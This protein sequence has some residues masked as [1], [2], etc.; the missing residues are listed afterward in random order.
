VR[1]AHS[2]FNVANSG[3]TPS[4]LARFGLAPRARKVR[5][6]SYC[7]LMIAISIGVEPSPAVGAL[8]SRA[9]V[10]QRFR[11]VLVAF[12]RRVVERGEAPLRADLLDVGRRSRTAGTPPPRLPPPG[13]GSLGS[14]ACPPTPA[15]PA[16]LRDLAPPPCPGGGG[17]L[18][19]MFE[20]V[21][22]AGRRRDD[23]IARHAGIVVA[24]ARVAVVDDLGHQP[25]IRSLGEQES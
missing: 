9:A 15:R 17:S 21:A 23:A 11:H 14:I 3:A 7:P 12:A 19:L 25:G 2:L 8:T 16:S 1:S 18:R 24:A 22:R 13:G 6:R 4:S 10:E 5:A 20:F